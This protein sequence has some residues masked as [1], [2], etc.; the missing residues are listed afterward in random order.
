MST[1]T[2]DPFKQ[3]LR[4]I[5][6]LALLAAIAF[7]AVLGAVEK[8]GTVEIVGNKRVRSSVLLEK[9][10]T[11]VG[12]DLD[13]DKIASDIRKLWKLGFFEADIEVTR[14]DLGSGKTGVRF[15]VR[16]KPAIVEIKFTGNEEFTE[17]DLKK[18]LEVKLYR[19]VDESLLAA[20]ADRLEKKYAEK[21]YFLARVR[22]K[23][24]AEGKNEATVVF[25]IE[26]QGQVLVGDV[27][28]F[29]NTSIAD[30]ELV[31][32]MA[33]QPFTRSSNF[34]SASYFK[35]EAVERDSEFLSFYYKDKGFADVQV[36]KPS[37]L[38]DTDKKFV[39]MTFR[40]DEGRQ[41]NVR[42]ISV[43]GDVEELFDPQDLIDNLR[44]QDGDLFRYSFFVRDI[45]YLADRYGELGYAFAD[46]NPKTEFNK[47]EGWVDINYVIDRGDKVYFGGIDIVGNTKTRDNVIR[48]EVEFDPAALYN[49]TLLTDTK[50]NLTRLGFFEEVRVVKD[51][52]TEDPALTN[53]E[54]KVKE[55]STGHFQA[56]LGF[57]P[58]GET[59]QKW[60]G[61]G[62]YE[63][64]NQFG[65]GWEANI[66]AR[67]T[68]SEDYQL[69][70]GF[71]NPRVFDSL[72]S[73]GINAGYG[74]Q[75]RRFSIGLEIVREERSLSVTVGRRFL[76]K[77]SGSLTLARNDYRS[78]KQLSVLKG[79]RV[80]GTK[81]SATFAL[82]RKDLNNYIDPSE[83][84]YLVAK[85]GVIGTF[86]GGDYNY[87]ENT[88]SATW[89]LPL[90]F[91][92]SY[93]TYFKFFG[94]FGKLWPTESTGIPQS[95]RYRLGGPYNLRG[96]EFSEVGPYQ[97]RG[98]SALGDMLNYNVG[99][100]KQLYFQFEYLVP[101]IP[102]AGIKT[103]F[104]TDMG[105]VFLESEEISFAE[106]E[107]DFGFGFR[108]LTPLGPFRFEWATPYDKKTGKLGKAK[109]IFNIGY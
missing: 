74:Q 26:E 10:S 17:E 36:S 67:Y 41:Y 54:I 15:R 80:D 87:M 70:A 35:R 3:F 79:F 28:I 9:L 106:F 55:K 64:K 81:N 29:G 6:R 51:R 88:F 52:D 65:R 2:C 27:E 20:D 1:R 13:K 60:Y 62:M 19:I 31:E 109:F 96:F 37:I 76:D 91:S 107:Y 93:R 92:D 102:K 104:F 12:D 8:V 84:T 86:L 63:E 53:I 95:E 99:G 69:E 94:Q 72:W 25:E 61:Q 68:N 50:T 39:R 40:V 46:V 103:V 89:Y 18:H 108:W 38:M 82:S 44:I 85:H 11:K 73:F 21:G 105:S 5:T 48:R 24:E 59:N 42:K 32:R 47:E 30:K 7:P 34:G 66:V 97:R 43:S 71:L 90:D 56:S 58:K 77:F 78:K 57:I 23:I 98:L 14:H 4:T 22:Y 83:G 45:E 49:G 16:E 100:D 101:L 75:L 33:S